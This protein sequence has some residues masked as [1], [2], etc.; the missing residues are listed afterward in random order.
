MFWGL[1]DGHSWLNNYP[2]I[3]RTNHAL[4]FDRQLRPK[5][6]HAAVVDA[7]EAARGSASP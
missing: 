3:G 7:L 1:D 2:V 4:L 6:A 5:P